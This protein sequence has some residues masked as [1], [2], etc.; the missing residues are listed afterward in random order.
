MRQG[1]H[2]VCVGEVMIDVVARLPGTLATGSD[3]PAP[4]RLLAGGSGANT[5]RWLGDRG[6][7]AT[8]LA[9]VGHDYHEL[10][11]RLDDTSRDR[12]GL[13]ELLAVDP[14]HLTG[15][16]I[17]L[18][19]V[20]GERTMVPDA[21]ANAAFSPD[22]VDE[23]VFRAGRHLHLS[24]YLMFGRARLAGLW[25]LTLARAAGMSVSVDASSAAPLVRLGADA[26]YRLI[27]GGLLLFA[28]GD[29]AAVLTGESDPTRAVAQLAARYGQAIVKCGSDGA[30]WAGAGDIRQVAGRP[31]AVIDSTGAGD[32]FTAGYLHAI[33]SGAGP[34]E[35]L[36]AANLLGS[37]ACQRLG[38]QP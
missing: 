3:T 4:I 32:A 2:V 37:A 35:A 27:G 26:F 23:R 24:A 30:L 19:G 11:R 12:P 16:C 34:A 36:Q 9:R 22:D 28:N 13:T 6:T 5:A 29:E 17:V 14:H 10:S 21:G 38:G 1:W 33:G 15:R 25:T 8:L 31:I 7:P 20:T 18:I